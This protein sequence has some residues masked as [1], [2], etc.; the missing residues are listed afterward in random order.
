M[1]ILTLLCL[2]AYKAYVLSLGPH[3]HT[4][5][6]FLDFT[7]AVTPGTLVMEVSTIYVREYDT[8]RIGHLERVTEEPFYTPEQWAEL[9]EK[10]EPI[11]LERVWYIKSLAASETKRWTNADFIRVIGS[12]DDPWRI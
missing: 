1:N 9:G 2:S 8:I 7:Q 4:S 3:T 10:D 11:P 6:T 5:K 12:S